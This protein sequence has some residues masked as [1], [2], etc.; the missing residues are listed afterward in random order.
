MAEF[1]KYFYALGLAA[2][3]SG[4]ASQAFAQGNTVTC[5][6][7]AGVIP[8]IREESFAELVGDYILDCTGGIPTP[9]NQVVQR[10]DITLTLSANVTSRLLTTEFPTSNFNEALLIIDEP[11]SPLNPSRPLRACGA[12]GSPDQTVVLGSVTRGDGICEIRSNGNPLQTYD[13]SGN[14][15]G[16]QT[17]D[18]SAGRPA[19]NSWGCGRPNVFQGR[20]G[21]FSAPNQV[22]FNGIPF[23]PPGSTLLDSGA[24]VLNHRILRFTNIRVAAPAAVTGGLLTA[25]SMSISI[26]ASTAISLPVNI[27]TVA[28]VQRGLQPVTTAGRF[29]YVQCIEPSHPPFSTVSFRE[30]F[31]AAF[32]TKGIEQKLA[33]GSTLDYSYAGGTSYTFGGNFINQNVPGALYFTESGFV[34]NGAS[35]WANPSPNPPLGIGTTPVTGGTPLT[36]R[37]NVNLAGIASQG[38]RIALTFRD[39]PAGV[40][41]SV[42]QAVNLVRTDDGVTVSGRAVRVNTDT[43]GANTPSAFSGVTYFSTTPSTS[44]YNP[45]SGNLVVYEIIFTDPTRQ[46]DIT[47]PVQVSYTPNL[48]S[49]LPEP[50]KTAQVAGG[51]APFILSTDSVTT[52]SNSSNTLPIPRFRSASGFAD[53]F[54]INKC[55]CN[56]LFPWVVS[57]AG[58]DTGI[59]I[60]NTSK[61]PSAAEGFSNAIQAQDGSVQFWY[62]T[63]VGA[64]TIPTQCTNTSSPGTCPGTP[65][66]VKA[67]DVLTYVLSQ[68]STQWG[69]DNRAAG[70]SGYIIAQTGFQ[71]C[72]AF[73]YISALG[74]GP[75]SPG[76]SVGY[77]GLVLDTSSPLPPRTAQQGESL[78]N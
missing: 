44:V 69:L 29:D 38:T 70:F 19:A 20:Q 28:N 46:E 68:G 22:V 24:T 3:L 14:T 11:N 62:Y 21:T 40:T 54:R 50:G 56:L 78:G 35:G 18:G 39:V 2:L 32:K 9:A 53:L 76:M 67:G 72:H 13:G 58:Y 25:V 45:I 66:L 64:D 12:P 63:A 23:D 1:R 37:N 6:A 41:I 60:A 26:N 57:A 48:A 31:V 15:W 65:Q 71:Y 59:A 7:T 34:S 4:S 74:A 77:L 43:R 42:P 61:Q 16:T 51:F 47:I 36:N 30:G 49:N 33:N 8:V 5:T 73:A 10:V 75:T 27:Q 52:W 55:A 17:C